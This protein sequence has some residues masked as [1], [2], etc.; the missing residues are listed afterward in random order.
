MSVPSWPKKRYINTLPFLSFLL[1]PYPLDLVLTYE[2]NIAF[3]VI[4]DLTITSNAILH[5]YVSTRSNGYGSETTLPQLT[6]WG[7]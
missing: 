5:S 6:D 3:D 4:V 1:L 7:G 2:C